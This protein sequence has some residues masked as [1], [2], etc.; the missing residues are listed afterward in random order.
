MILVA[1]G[2]GTLGTRLVRS[3]AQ[4]GMP[5]RVLTRDPERARQLEDTNVEVVTGDVRDQ[6][7]VARA[8]QGADTIV[9]A[10]Q[11]F[12]GTGGVSPATVDRA[13]NIA[14]I[15]A[16]EATG[17][18]IVVVSVV[19]ASPDSPMELCREKF[20]A[21]QHLR[22][23]KCHWTIVRATPFVETWG[24]IMGEPLRTKHK[25]MVFGRGRNPINFVSAADISALVERA[26]DDPG[27]H[28]RV[29]ELG[30]PEN[31]TFDQF[32][33]TLQN[34][35]GC[36]GKVAHIPLP[37][38]RTMAIVTAKLKP[39]LSRQARAAIVMDTSDMTFDDTA[40]RREFPDLPTTD[41]TTALKGHLVD[42]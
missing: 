37:A 7:D 9:S 4:R 35:L 20:A 29:L 15:D 41:V 30:G 23:S 26:L 42:A 1:G 21:E 24:T 33:A 18:G 16:A 3:L 36:E 27:L 32:A 12:V 25:T 22:A 8:V 34:V 5:V 11:G 14:L 28:G 38:L 17:A 13:G 19:G 6:A 39:A 2:T 31:L 10:V 40:I